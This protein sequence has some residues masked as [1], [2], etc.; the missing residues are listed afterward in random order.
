MMERCNFKNCNK[1][2]PLSSTK[3]RCGQRFCSKHRLPEIHDCS[4]DYKSEYKD[5]LKQQNPTIKAV[6][7]IK[8]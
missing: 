5:R 4:Y 3:C 2:L 6:K 1:K 8:V 7:I